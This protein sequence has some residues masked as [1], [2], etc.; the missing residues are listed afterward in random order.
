M[1]MVKR[2]GHRLIALAL[3]FLL[4]GNILVYQNAKAVELSSIERIAGSTDM[5]T[6]IEIALVHNPGIAPAVILASPT[7]Y[8]DALAGIPF[9]QQI[10]APILWVGPTPKESEAVFN[11]IKEHCDINGTIYILG[12]YSSIPKSFGTALR[13]LGY[14]Q[15]QIVRLRGSNHYETAI[16]IAQNVEYKG[17]PVIITSGEN[18]DQLAGVAA[19]AA[20]KESPIL[21]LP[22]KGSI[23]KSLS[24]YLNSISAKDSISIL[25]IG[26]TKAIPNKLI[27]EL[28]SKVANLG[29]NDI[30]RISGASPYDLMAQ[31]NKQAWFNKSKEDGEKLPISKITLTK[32]DNYT[33]AIS[34]AILAAQ[35][36][37][38]LIFIEEAMPKESI[39]L[40]KDINHWNT[41]ADSYLRH[42]TV[43]G[44]FEDLSARVI[45]EAD[46][47]STIGKPLGED[48]QVWTYAEM[49]QSTEL[50]YGMVG[51]DNSIIVSDLYYNSLHSISIDTGI[52]MLTNSSDVVDEYGRP[53]GAHKDGLINESMFNSPGGIARD[54][55]GTLYIVDTGNG[56][57]RTI[58][59]NMNVKTLVK[60]LKHPTGIVINSKGEIFVTETLNHRILK[61]DK[62]GRWTVFAGGEYAKLNGEVVGAFADGKGEKAKFNEPQGLAIDSENNLYVAD[63]ANQRIRKVN[64]E[65][66]V[67]TIAG[68]GL[69]LIKNTSYIQGGYQDGDGEDAKFNFPLGLTVGADNTIYVAD[70][71]NHCIRMITPEGVVST[72]VGSIEPG[73]RNGNAVLARFNQPR[74][75][76]LLKDGRL[77]IL[78]KGNALLRVYLPA[79]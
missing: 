5:E 72:L 44:G 63:S 65:G 38:P 70:T 17:N 73:I 41:Q 33:N 36:N 20:A 4:L 76:L 18:Y 25:I 47:L 6:A 45:A 34:G 30:T 74:D 79:Q 12:D 14:Q 50:N 24:N 48:G 16:R 60:D 1:D 13:E 22:S 57:I 10:Q 43:L 27:A 71:Y 78:D 37:S 40:L 62:L 51:E 9:A 52:L 3:T 35:N 7:N 67:T 2:A 75:V 61:V 66:I 23:P 42:M 26:D 15:N 55:D 29:S 64:T 58:D 28:Q 46:S 59:Q 56:A 31:V 49:H 8:Y 21:F 39:K 54:K 69:E 53:L 68:S 77:I 32:G 19:M 11:H